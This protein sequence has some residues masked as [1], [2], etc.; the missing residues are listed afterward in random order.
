MGEALHFQKAWVLPGAEEPTELWIADGVIVEGPVSGAQSRSAECWVLPGL[1]DAHCHI[2]LGPEGAVDAAT[3]RRQALEDLS[4]G[5]MLIRD[6]GSPAD[7]RWVQQDGDLPRLLRAGRHVARPKRY[8]RGVGAEVEPAD[9]V[10]QVRHE[11][12]SGD[13]WVKLVGD[14]IDRSVGDLAPLWPAD[15]AAQAI[16]AAH[17][18]GARV[19]AHCFGEQSVAELVSA[20]IDC[21]E[22]GTG[23]T[24]EVIEEMV[25][26]GTALVPTMINLARFPMY[27]APAKD[28]YPTYFTHMTDLYERR[29]A[30]IGK[31]VEAGVQ[32]YS[33]TDAGTVVPHGQI[34]SEIEELAEVGGNGFALGAASWRA[35]GW[36]GADVLTTGASADLIVLD[37]DPREDLTALYRPASLVLRGRVVH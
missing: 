11:A 19:T 25:R 6:A 37:A 16:A 31:A 4:A 21:I 15:V 20:G 26:R 22:H 17:E 14:W 13:G 10:E 12:R 5:T 34:R 1:V 28:K 2:G 29:K 8:L 7:T 3:A 32:V 33:G 30:T 18:E 24:D 27:A 23:M 36:L 9:L 35:R